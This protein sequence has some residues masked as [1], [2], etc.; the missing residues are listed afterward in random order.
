MKKRLGT[1]FL[2]AAV[3]FTSV[4]AVPY[5]G[6]QPAAAATTK[7]PTTSSSSELTEKSADGRVTETG[8]TFQIS[9]NEA[10]ITGYT[11]TVKDLKVP[12]KISIP[13][14]VTVPGTTQGSG[15]TNT[16][17]G[18]G[19]GTTTQGTGTSKIKATSSKT[20]EPEVP[21]NDYVVTAIADNAFNSKL[22]IKSIVMSNS[23][24]NGRTNGIKK[25]GKKAFFGCHDLTSV[26]IAATTTEIGTG[27]FADC[28]ALTSIK[29]ADG[30]QNFK[31]IDGALYSYSTES[32]SG[33]YRL[34]QYPLGNKSAEY[35]VSE[36]LGFT[37]GSIGQEAFLG[38]Q[39]L[40]TVELPITVKTIG[41]RAFAQCKKLKTVTLP[42]DLATLGTEA[43][44]GDIALEEIT[45]PETVT[46]INAGTFQDCQALKSA[47][48]PEKLT[49]IGANAFQNCKALGDVELPSGVASIGER[50]Y[51]QC[52]SLK[53][54]SIPMK[55]NVIGKDAFDGAP[56]KI[57][58][59][60]G[61]QAS[62]Y[63]KQYNLETERI[64]T[65]EFYTDNSYRT[66]IS[67]QEVVE[68]TDATLPEFK[69]EDGYEVTGWSADHKKI[70][71]DLR[72]YP[73][74]KKV[75]EVKFTDPYNGRETTVKVTDGG[76][77]E[78][79]D[80]T[81]E[82]F[83]LRWNPSIP[84]DVHSNQA[85]SAV[86]TSNTTGK[87][88]QP[89]TVKPE[90]VGDTI[91]SGKNNYQV[92]SADPYNP[93]VAFIGLEGTEA[94]T[95]AK[96]SALTL[97]A[98]KSKKT[99]ASKT[100]STSKKKTTASK[101]TS[102]SDKKTAAAKTAT[103]KKDTEKY[104]SIAVKIPASISIDGVTYKVTEVA[105][106]ALNNNM[107]ITS[108]EVGGNVKEIKGK[109]FYKC[110]RL[111]KVRLKTKKIIAMGSGA[112]KGVKAKATFYTFNSKI[113][114]Y[115]S[116]LKKAGVKKPTMKQL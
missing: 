65:V 84:D 86:W 101:A 88:I 11:G 28:I 81:M 78:A 10:T 50:A 12:I 52:S 96:N 97:K 39:N 85:V 49:A 3:A 103:D 1:A 33:I 36:S 20:K 9:G 58:C 34:E 35:K 41:D 109:A 79:P 69:A 87:E 59:H 68:E 8:F 76:A 111:S 74:Q 71:Q 22:G 98:T 105:A 55:T 18:T 44:Q 80:W 4:Q 77:P 40:E 73:I 100:T 114:K 91:T 47:K 46:T 30:N 25:I 62:T 93:T 56:V 45:L 53:M 2:A 107:N 19:T 42:Q 26:T 6:V 54:I 99:T 23:T 92:I 27:T 90:D 104:D 102:T 112:F 43:F 51:A 29:V 24:T 63:A 110:S 60:S 115:K 82:G 83:S 66:L 116:L 67:S 16:G 89:G 113:S 31:T 14:T 57:H 5:M 48:L 70:K 17:T 95:S 7:K 37:L 21:T 15:T 108:V 75:Y 64:F 38:S 72:I 32:G 94:E 106:K 13:Q 61:S